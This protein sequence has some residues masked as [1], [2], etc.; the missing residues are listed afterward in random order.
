MT[1]PESTTSNYGWALWHLEQANRPNAYIEAAK[2]HASLAQAR[3]KLALVDA[4][5]R[6]IETTDGSTWSGDFDD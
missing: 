6:G 5:L 4:Q 2:L 3:A 1:R